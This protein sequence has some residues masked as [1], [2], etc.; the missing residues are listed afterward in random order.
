MNHARFH[1]N[2]HALASIKIFPHFQRGE[3]LRGEEITLLHP[4]FQPLIPQNFEA[5]PAM[6]S[7]K[8]AYNT[9]SNSF[10]Q[11]RVALFL[12]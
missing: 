3:S 9:L 10:K 11:I 2:F 5:T 6:L 12:V 7:E 4:Y 1:K 8:T